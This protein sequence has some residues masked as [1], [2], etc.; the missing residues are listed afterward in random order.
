MSIFRHVQTL[1]QVSQ[2]TNLDQTGNTFVVVPSDFDRAEDFQL[3]FRVFIDATQSGGVTAPTTS[4]QIE[5]SHDG[6]SWVQALPATQL[7]SDTTVNQFQSITA[8]G[9]FVRA[10]TVLGGGTK[11][12]HT[13]TVKLACNGAFRL[14]RQGAG[15]QA[16]VG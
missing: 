16:L 8:L 9:P 2:A 15:G 10:R 14:A 12:N 4:V 11:P 5:T 6:T 7:N 3:G 1:L 13:V